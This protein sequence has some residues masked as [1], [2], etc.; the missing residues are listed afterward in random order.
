M[1]GIFEFKAVFMV[2]LVLLALTT[3]VAGPLFSQAEGSVP[4]YLGFYALNIPGFQWHAGVKLEVEYQRL[5]GTLNLD[6]TRTPLFEAEGQDPVPLTLDQTSR[7]LLAIDTKK[8]FDIVGLRAHTTGAD[9]SPQSFFVVF[10]AIS[11]DKRVSLIPTLTSSHSKG[12]SDSKGPGGD[13]PTFSP[14]G[15]GF[16][17]SY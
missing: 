14:T 5:T 3:L 11:G 4:D 2:R 13:G 7:L 16:T 1:V 9:G 6:H 17:G 12:G 15:S 10:I 8:P